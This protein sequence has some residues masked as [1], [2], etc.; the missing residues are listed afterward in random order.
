MIVW[1]LG[2]L[3]K[4]TNVT[5]TALVTHCEKYLI[6]DHLEVSHFGTQHFYSIKCYD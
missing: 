3:N 4:K 5:F 2:V 6:K 1:L